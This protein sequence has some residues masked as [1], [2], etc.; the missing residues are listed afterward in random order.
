MIQTTAIKLL[1]SDFI[2]S[3]DSN[4]KY[5]GL[6]CILEFLEQ[7]DSKLENFKPY[8]F[9]S[10]NSKDSM[11]RIKSLEIIKI[12]TNEQTGVKLV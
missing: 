1:I 4:L 12:M 3:M 2:E 6:S 7:D 9:E 10:L 11:I 8:I 5:L